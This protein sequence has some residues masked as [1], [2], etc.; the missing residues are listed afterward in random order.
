MA[1]CVLLFPSPAVGAAGVPVNVGEAIGAF[2][3]TAAATKAVVA[4]VV[5]SSPKV[6]VGAAGVPVNVGEA[7]GAAPSVERPLAASVAER[8]ERPVAV[9]ARE[10]SAPVP[11]NPSSV[12][13]ESETVFSV[14]AAGLPAFE[15]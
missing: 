14:K 7:K 6:A 2:G 1:S 12:L 15:T 9:V 3:A 8:S 4:S 13:F 11:S 5:L 10:T